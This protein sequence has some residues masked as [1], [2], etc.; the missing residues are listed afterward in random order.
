MSALKEVRRLL[1]DIEREL[2]GYGK[3]VREILFD[4]RSSDYV[5]L[6]T[7]VNS[8]CL[9]ED[10]SFADSWCESLKCFNADKGVFTIDEMHLLMS[11]GKNFGYGDTE[12]QLKLIHITTEYFE[13]YERSAADEASK[14]GKLKLMLPV[15]AGLVVCILMI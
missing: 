5:V 2:K 4:L 8:M 12:E 10:E 3:P 9:Y 7:F 14:Q 6:S 11:F 15:Y 13:E 1:L